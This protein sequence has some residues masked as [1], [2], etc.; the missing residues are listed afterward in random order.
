M[1]K[2]R[3]EDVVHVVMTDHYIQRRKPARDLLA[4]LVERHDET[5]SRT[6]EKPA[7]YKGEVALYYPSDLPPAD[8]E[9]YLGIAQVKQNSNFRPPDLSR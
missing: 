4:P 8:K 6:N 1:P 2:R 3:A 7:A 9:L 5:G